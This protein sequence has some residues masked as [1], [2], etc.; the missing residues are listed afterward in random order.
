[1]A[2][3]RGVS[4]RL[5]RG[6]SLAVVGES[7]AGK[8]TLG[9]SIIGLAEGRAAGRIIFNGED[10][11]LL[12]EK[13]LRKK[14]WRE[15]A[16]V[17]QNVE[18]ALNPVMRVLDQV[19]EPLVAHGMMSPE[20]AKQRAAKALQD[21]RLPD[22]TLKAYPHQLS[23]GEK[24]RVL[25]AMAMAGDPA[26]LILDEPTSSLDN[27]SRKGIL[28]W[29]REQRSERAMLV[30]THDLATAAALGDEIA[31]LYGGQILEQ[32]PTGLI[33]NQPRH[34][35][36]R[37]LLRAYP[38]MNRTKDL[39]G[40][41]G[42]AGWVA[43]GC[44]FA[45]R[46]TQRLAICQQEAPPL[47]QT[48]GRLLACH[49]G[50][51]IPLLSIRG[52]TVDYDSF[53][54]VASVDL[55][56]YEGET[57]ALVGPSG[58]GKTTLAKAVMGLVEP[59]EGEVSVEQKKVVRR[60]KGFYRR[61]QMVFQN[62]WESMSHRLSVQAIVHEPLDIQGL[63]TATE[64]AAKVKQV[65]EEVELPSDNDFLD[66]YPHQLSGGELQRVAIARALV[67]D[68][69][70]LI[71][72]EATSRLDVSIQAKVLRLLLDIQEQ[73]GLGMLF[74]THDIALAR[75][76]A[77]RI[78]VMDSGSIVE[79]NLSSELVSNP[80]HPCSRALINSAPSLLLDGKTE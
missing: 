7:G 69:K 24:Q 51:V 31:V 35:Y 8:S 25:I 49:R 3:L 67:L 22:R 79:N 77:D 60:D 41:T 61:V 14:R 53:R 59:V 57:L 18:D 63:G 16:I 65:L 27:I 33:L 78:A 10:L 32:G 68:P 17:F 54:A 70:L 9:L 5:E 72:D 48:D 29:L 4:L 21:A 66:R 42:S 71:A 47:K 2:A 62:P 43:A 44:P 74:I 20:E 39:Q 64:R 56:L 76:V 23:G 1:M 26:L 11:L 58:S 46:C 40:I 12:P 13:R 34:P 55:T 50:G 19:K 6:G 36:T 45:P 80:L 38:D 75:K 28:D 73:R 15:I 30:L 52:L 37:G